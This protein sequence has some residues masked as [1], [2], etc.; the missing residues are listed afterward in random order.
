MPKIRQVHIEIRRMLE[1]SILSSRLDEMDDVGI[2]T[3]RENTGFW[4]TFGKQ[5]LRPGSSSSISQ[6]CF[7]PVA[8]Q[9]MNEYDAGWIG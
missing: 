3:I 1:N 4:D 2:I 6:P 8:G 5:L 9:A 7:C